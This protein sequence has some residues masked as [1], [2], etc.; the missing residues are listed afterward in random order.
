MKLGVVPMYR[1]CRPDRPAWRLERYDV[2][3]L[4]SF[5]RCLPATT[6][7][8]EFPR[9]NRTPEPMVEA[10]FCKHG[11]YEG[12]RMPLSEFARVMG[13]ELAPM[14]AQT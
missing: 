14:S 1:Q 7:F 2:V 5:F 8:A 3:D 9:E 13:T 12:Y 11:G 10:R 4:N 6:G